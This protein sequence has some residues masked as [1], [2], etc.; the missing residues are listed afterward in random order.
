MKALLA[1]MLAGA[2]LLALGGGAGAVSSP[3]LD[4]WWLSGAIQGHRFELQAGSYAEIHARTPEAR[5]LAA[6]LVGDNRHSLTEARALALRLHFAVPRAP[7]G[8]QQWLFL[9]LKA[10]HRGTVY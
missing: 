8:L 5:A 9:N 1:A 4:Q 10:M 7:S 2:A 6:Q 3:A